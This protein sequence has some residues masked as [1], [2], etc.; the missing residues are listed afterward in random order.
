MVTGCMKLMMEKGILVV[1]SR[2]I[3]QWR[4]E[5]FGEE[6]GGSRMTN[7]VH[8][9]SQLRDQVISLGRLEDHK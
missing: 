7:D 2:E 8:E 5:V 6:K 3:K 9:V 4:S 1:T